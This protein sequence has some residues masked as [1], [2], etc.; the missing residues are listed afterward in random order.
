MPISLLSVQ[1][2]RS[3]R[4][5]W[6]RLGGVNVVLGP[7]GSGKTNLY[8]SLALLVEA[9]QGRLAQSVAREGGMPSL[10]WAGGHR[11]HER[12][13]V[14]VEVRFD[15]FAYRIE[16]GL[17][18]GIQT[19]FMLDPEVK[20]ES[21][22]FAEGRRKPVKL[23]ERA[24]PTAWMRD[25]DGKRVTY[26]R[27]LS[28]SESVLSQLRDRHRYPEVASIAERIQG[29]RFYHHFRTDPEAPL[30]QPQV[31]VRTHVLGAAGDDLAAAIQTI[32]EV[33]G[34]RALDDAVADA[35]P[36]GRVLVH[37]DE[38]LRVGVRMEM[39][40][41][42]RALEARELSD[43]T[44][45]YLCLVAALLTPRPPEL[46]ALNEPETSLHPQLLAPLGRLVARASRASQLFVTTHSQELAAHIEEAAAAR[47]VALALVDGETRI[48]GQRF[49][50]DGDGEEEPR[51]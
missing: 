15:A 13:G 28:S 44:L 2:Y 22:T 30:R 43:G 23:M 32:R 19:I 16:I 6:T 31:G 34:E 1:G 12:H 49:D 45:R 9:A 14:M 33:G 11:K 18:T 24:G 42:R 36:G 20:E 26:P 46:L 29:W 50:E 39:P 41:I 25:D 3:I 40:G 10:M 5:V 48:A 21:V 47:T 35:F 7:N 27:E 17:V 8:R 37:A 38:M 4:T 51:R